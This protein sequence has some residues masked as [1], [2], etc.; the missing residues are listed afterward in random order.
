MSDA[1]WKTLWRISD[2][3]DLGGWGGVK[4]S[5]RWTSLGR[6]VVYMAESPAGALLEILAHLEFVEGELPDEYQ[7]IEI[8]VPEELAV[9][10]LQPRKESMWKEQP[11]LTRRIGDIW[12]TTGE[13]SLAR[14]PSAIVPRTRNYL[15]NPMHPGA[16]KLEVREVIRA[17]FDNR[18]LRFGAR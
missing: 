11:A 5:S 16:K 3:A 14:V 13:T 8:A 4:F 6:R 15:L 12:L 2:Y 17:R 7:L 10:D 1:G 18:L 9:S